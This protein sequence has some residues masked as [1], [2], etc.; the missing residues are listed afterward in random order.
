MKKNR[1]A[2]WVHEI[3]W[4]VP[5][6]GLVAGSVLM[7]FAYLAGNASLFEALIRFYLGGG[8]LVSVLSAAKERRMK[9]QRQEAQARKAIRRRERSLR[10]EKKTCMID[11]SIK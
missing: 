4:S 8:A 2:Y 6:L 11:F 3:L 10:T 7:A 1:K 5:A 9:K